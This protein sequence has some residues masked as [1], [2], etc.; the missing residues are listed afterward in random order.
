MSLEVVIKLSFKSKNKFFCHS[1]VENLLSVYK[2]LLEQANHYILNE[3]NKENLSPIL[4]GIFSIEICRLISKNP[5]PCRKL[6]RF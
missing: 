4:N 1:S 3:I 2:N 6:R 5:Y